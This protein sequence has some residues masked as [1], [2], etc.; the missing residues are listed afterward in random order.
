[1]NSLHC[2]FIAKDTK[3]IPTPNQSFLADGSVELDH[4]E[5]TREE[6]IEKMETLN[7]SK[8]PSL[9]GIHLRVM[10]ELKSEIAELLAILCNLL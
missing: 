2:V 3:E 7:I 9:D 1:M 10:K 5:V 6:V 8:S 4:T